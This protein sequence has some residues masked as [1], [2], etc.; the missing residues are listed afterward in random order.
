MIVKANQAATD[1]Q[2]PLLQETRVTKAGEATP[3]PAVPTQVLT[4][5]L[6]A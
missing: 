5:S 2:A 1:S 3:V 6:V 4:A